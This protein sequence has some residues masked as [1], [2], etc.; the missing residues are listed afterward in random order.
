MFVWGHGPRQCGNKSR[1]V[2]GGDGT[3]R[4]SEWRTFK[5]FVTRLLVS[6]FLTTLA[7]GHHYEMYSAAS[8]V[9]P[10]TALSSLAQDLQQQ[11]SD[12][13][14]ELRTRLETIRYELTCEVRLLRESLAND[15][16]AIGG[17]VVQATNE[18]SGL[19][20]KF[21][22]GVR[23]VTEETDAIKSELRSQKAELYAVR[24]SVYDVKEEMMDKENEIMNKLHRTNQTLL[25]HLFDL[26]RQVRRMNDS[27]LRTLMAAATRRIPSREDYYPI[28]THHSFGFA[29]DRNLT[30]HGCLTDFGPPDEG[31]MEEHTDH[32]PDQHPDQHPE[33]RGTTA[34]PMGEYPPMRPGRPVLP[35][36]CKDPNGEPYLEFQPMPRDCRMVYDMGLM[37]TGVY[38]IQPPGLPAQEVYCDHHTA[39]GG[40]TVIVARMKLPRHIPFNRSWAQYEHGFG[41]PA[42][43]YWIGLQTLHALTSGRTHVMRADMEDWEGNT[44]YASYDFFSVSGPEDRYRLRVSGYSGTAGDSMRHSNLQQFSTFDRDHDQEDW[45]SCS[46]ARGGGGWWWGRCACTQPTGQYRRGHYHG[47]ERGV[48]WWHW[49]DTNYSLKTLILKIRAKE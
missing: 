7:S 40:W 46:R 41:D 42:K 17:K 8:T 37:Q 19:K 44:A 39:G 34:S 6:F 49:K 15:S 35:E 20:K 38:R 22:K 28:D 29:E 23:K 27:F 4:A 21:R 25:C 36:D 32:H 2:T 14:A 3:L 47:E 5:M 48:T 33:G 12:L 16:Q 18:V 1:C 13:R 9:A 26:Q 31:F 45:S 10:L 11:V 24:N 30:T 43:E